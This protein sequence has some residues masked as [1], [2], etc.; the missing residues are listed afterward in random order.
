MS[1]ETRSDFVCSKFFKVW[2]SAQSFSSFRGDQ[3]L[4]KKSCVLKESHAHGPTLEL[5]DTPSPP[6][7]SPPS[8]QKGGVRETRWIC[9]ILAARTRLRAA[10][11]NYLYSNH[12]HHLNRELYRAVCKAIT[13]GSLAVSLATTCRHYTRTY[14]LSYPF[15]SFFSR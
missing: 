14:S 15:F 11:I 12:H 3:W 8:P 2:F 10:G 13:L 1:P 5:A 4:I 7:L 6:L 9:A